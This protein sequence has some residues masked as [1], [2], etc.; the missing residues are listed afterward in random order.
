MALGAAWIVRLYRHLKPWLEAL[1]EQYAT[2]ETAGLTPGLL[3]FPAFLIR[4]TDEVARARRYQRE[5]ALVAG[6][7]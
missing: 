2:Q 5:L 3:H 6:A 4:L 7:K 1:E